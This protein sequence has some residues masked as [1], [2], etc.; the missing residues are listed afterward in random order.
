M[1]DK[2]NAYWWLPWAVVVAVAV[3]VSVISWYYTS[4]YF[5]APWSTA[6]I[7]VTQMAISTFES[8][9]ASIA[10]YWDMRIMALTGI[11]L[12]FI[13][14][15]SLWVYGELANDAKT[16]TD[17]VTK[18]FVWY[19]GTVLVVMGLQVVPSTF[20]KAEIFQNT[21]TSADQHR[22][23][24]RLRSEL[25]KLGFDAVETYHRPRDYGG[26]GGSFQLATSGNN[27]RLIQLSDLDAYPAKSMSFQLKD[28]TST[29][30]TITIHAISNQ[31]G[32]NPDYQNADGQTGKLEIAIT[33]TP[34]ANFDYQ[35][36][37]VRQ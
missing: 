3:T 4:W 20:I 13:V 18:G 2:T 17:T 10:P 14:G 31:N 29:D 32:P 34:T 8:G 16:N 7:V 28:S 26:G 35:Q 12:T 23:N 27:L 37:N 22:E 30:S 25:L 5:L 21:W 15:P 11:L 36:L 6:K 33:V 19:I 24:D 1:S 9:V